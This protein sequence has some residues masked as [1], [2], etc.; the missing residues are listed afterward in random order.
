MAMKRVRKVLEQFGLSE[1]EIEVYLV[2]IKHDDLSPYKI[3]K[4][5]N[6]P[7][8]TIYD[9]L[10]SLSL[11]G[12]VELEQSDG[13]T[14]QQT[15][16]KGKNPSELRKII[17]KR[18]NKLFA[19]E[20]DVVHILPDLKRDYHKGE[21]NTDVRYYPG[22]EGV[23]RVFALS[24]ELGIPTYAWTHLMPMDALG[25][26]WTNEV[27]DKSMKRAPDGEDK[28]LVPLN[29][30]TKHVIS[31][32]YGRNRD[33]LVR[34][35]IRYIDNYAFQM[36][37]RLEIQGEYV[38]MACAEGDEVWGMAIKSSALSSSLRAI[39][40]VMWNQATPITERMVRSWGENK[41][42]KKL[43]RKSQRLARH[44]R[45]NRCKSGL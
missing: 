36:Y 15:K 45:N 11:K 43:G 22:V 1:K 17:R 42:L 5:V 33:Y 10:M 31:Y 19:L 24:G 30:W 21:T 6:I 13:F 14:K 29:D 16:V 35:N 41:L 44:R 25:E 28:E 40:N 7:R 20:A 37:L 27:I 8:T 38:N 32:Q 2:C 26:E 23:K 34:N 9:I 39:Y 3:S 4:L 12:L 18:R